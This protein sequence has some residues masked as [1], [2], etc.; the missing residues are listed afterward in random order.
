MSPGAASTGS[1]LRD[2]GELSRMAV[3]RRPRQRT[4]S[5]VGGASE[6]GTAEAGSTAPLPDAAAASVSASCAGGV[7]W[8]SESHSEV[9][10]SSSSAPLPPAISVAASASSLRR[11]RWERGPPPRPART[12]G[13]VFPSSS[14]PRARLI[15]LC[16]PM[17]LLRA[18]LVR[19]AVRAERSGELSRASRRGWSRAR[20][21]GARL[22]LT[23]NMSLPTTGS[24]SSLVITVQSVENT[25]RQ[26]RTDGSNLSSDT[27]LAGTEHSKVSN[28]RRR[29]SAR[30]LH[31][32]AV[33]GIKDENGSA[34]VVLRV[35]SRSS[36]S[37][38]SI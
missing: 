17:R 14:S 32:V 35:R 16:F 4:I 34:S 31:T 18:D 23:S 8:P 3:P 20:A 19:R 1:V 13:L 25:E 2:S 38:H 30:R 6:A 11:T 15:K 33:A 10:C 21:T 29:F 37:S 27:T 9:V 24:G 5:G 22:L 12:R 36:R 7:S 28:F 26:S